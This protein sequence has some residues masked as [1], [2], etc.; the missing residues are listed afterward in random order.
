MI[1]ELP[2]K[3]NDVELDKA[4]RE[5]Y[6]QLQKSRESIHE[7][8]KRN[9]SINDWGISRIHQWENAENII[10][11]IGI[12]RF[13]KSKNCDIKKVATYYNRHKEEMEKMWKIAWS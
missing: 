11:L 9:K 4:S 13:E 10:M 6:R 8:Y 5:L 3:L 7:M 1:T 12:E 2:R